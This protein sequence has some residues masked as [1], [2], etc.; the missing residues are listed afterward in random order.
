MYSYVK[1]PLV[2]M[3]LSITFEGAVAKLCHAFY[4]SER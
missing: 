1:R 2:V 4:I 3:L